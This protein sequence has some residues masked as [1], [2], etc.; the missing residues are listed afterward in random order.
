MPPSAR[1][2]PV[3]DPLPAEPLAEA[4]REHAKAMHRVADAIV[5]ATAQREPVDQFYEG[6]TERLNLLCAWLKRRGPW[7]LASIPMVLVAVQAISPEAGKAL[8][9]VLQGIAG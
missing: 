9:A 2:I 8:A 6:A 5:A 4:V 7:L 3:S 1:R